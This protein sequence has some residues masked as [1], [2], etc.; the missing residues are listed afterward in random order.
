M[1]QIT[2]LIDR[3]VTV[4]TFRKPANGGTP[5]SENSRNPTVPPTRLGAT[6]AMPFLAP[7]ASV[8]SSVANTGLP[9]MPL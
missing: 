6:N 3:S 1:A 5:S 4:P 9:T 8:A 2:E 7:L